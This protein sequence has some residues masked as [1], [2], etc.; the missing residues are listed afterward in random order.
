MMVKTKKGNWAIHGLNLVSSDEILKKIIRAIE[1]DTLDQAYLQKITGNLAPIIVDKKH[2][3][4]KV[5]S[6]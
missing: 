5:Y 6:F 3:S 4:I 1:K 2:R